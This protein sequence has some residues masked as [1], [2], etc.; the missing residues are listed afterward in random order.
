MTHK[1]FE[2]VN[3][4]QFRLKETPTVSSNHNAILG[5]ETTK[6]YIELDPEL[7][8][9]IEYILTNNLQNCKTVI[10]KGNSNYL[11][12]NFSWTSNENMV[13]DKI[14]GYIEDTIKKYISPTLVDWG[15]EYRN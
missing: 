14:Y 11:G 2:N 5:I 3:G 10:R 13:S 12:L 7:I 1:L 9:D 15:I 4:N 6:N 8:R